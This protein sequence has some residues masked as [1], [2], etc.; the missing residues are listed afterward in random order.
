MPKIGRVKE[1]HVRHINLLLDHDTALYY[2]KRA[3]EQGSTLSDFLRRTL[4][5]GMI[6][7][8]AQE[9]EERLL[10]VIAKSGANG[11]ESRAVSIPENVLMSIYTSEQLLTAI[12]EARDIQ[13]LYAAQ[14]RARARIRRENGASHDK[15]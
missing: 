10:G 9:I 12:V 3:K 6:A 15:S 4:V 2:R 5:Q 11:G 1:D 14:D 8:T 13:Q 7:D